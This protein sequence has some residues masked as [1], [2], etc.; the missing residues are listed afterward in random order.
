MKKS[1]LEVALSEC[2]ELAEERRQRVN[3]LLASNNRL[4]ARAREG[5]A[6]LREVF[7]HGNKQSILVRDIGA[8]L[9]KWGALK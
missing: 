9:Q 5:D 7:K 6:L 2:V 1:V 4:L 3:D 8:H